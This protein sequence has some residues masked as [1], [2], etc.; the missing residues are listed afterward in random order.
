MNIAFK[1]TVVILAILAIVGG[2]TAAPSGP[3]GATA[4][5]SSNTTQTTS[6]RSTTSSP[7]GGFQ[8]PT[9]NAS[10]GIGNN[11]TG[12]NTT[13]NGSVS[14]GQGGVGGILSNPFDPKSYF[15]AIGSIFGGIGGTIVNIIAG[16][17]SSVPAPGQP[18]QYGS[19]AH[20]KN[21]VW[22]GVYHFIRVYS[23]PVAVVLLGVGTARAFMQED[24]YEG[25]KML[26]E[27]GKAF[28]LV[29]TTFVLMPLALHL[30]N[31]LIHWIAPSGADFMHT[32][33]NVS[34]LALGI[35]VGALTALFDSGT[36]ALGF[37]VLGIETAV[38][39]LTSA[40]LPVGWALKPYDGFLES[41]GNTVVFLFEVVL[42]LKVIQAASL[43]IL[44]AL[45]FH[46]IHGTATS[47]AIILGGLVFAL[48]ILP[49]SML[50]HANDAASFGL[51]I[52]SA[53][54]K[55][56]D[57]A[58]KA[59]ERVGDEV[60]Q[61]YEDYT[62]DNFTSERSSMRV[63]KSRGNRELPGSYS[64]NSNGRPRSKKNGVDA[65]TVQR[66]KD[67]VDWDDKYRYN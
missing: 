33:G 26:K 40:L 30:T 46:S 4:N 23:M 35:G 9:G 2:A 14:G 45:P 12:N 6:A 63:G 31:Q 44:F 21:G 53:Q 49:K 18:D 48:I 1:L 34:K 32:P 24:I 54:S 7:F 36:F 17:I 59:R 20:P 29:I 3:P 60:V 16:M 19:W 15:K 66:T 5:N 41:I 56:T 50:N 51:G 62:S 28:A 43:R 61:R 37:I 58:E 57:Y 67:R 8:M 13:A 39:V 22:P 11:A 25:R 52:R 47:L 27:V 42:V 64:D 65:T 38:I 55:T 10:V